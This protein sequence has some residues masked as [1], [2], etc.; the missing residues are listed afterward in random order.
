MEITSRKENS[1]AVVCVKGRIIRE[2]QADLRKALED[3]IE[4]GIKGIVLD[5]NE[6]DYLDSSGLGCCAAVRK[7]LQEKKSGAMVMFGASPNIEKMWNL[8]RL[9]LV[10]P[11]CQDLK[12][13]LAKLEAE[14]SASGL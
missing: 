7:S 5:F 11:I 6:V 14:A 10:I 9:P 1:F 4:E 13:S 8:I 2:N 3:L 12:E